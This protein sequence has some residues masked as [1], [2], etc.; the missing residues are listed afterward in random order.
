MADDHLNVAVATDGTLYAA[1]KTSYDSGIY[2]VIALLV[3]RPNGAWDPLREVDRRGTRPIVLI[4]EATTMLRVIY[5]ASEVHDDILEKTTTLAALDFSNDAHVAL[6]G[7]YNNVTSAK[8]NITG[9][10]LILAGGVSATGTAALTWTHPGAPQTHDS[11]VFTSVGTSVAGE[12][13]I[14][15]DL[16]LD[17][18]EIVSVPDAGSVTV[19]G[20][21]G[22]DYEPKADFVGADPFTF[23]A[24]SGSNWSAVATV[25][26]V[27]ASAD[28]LVG[29]WSLDEG[30]GATVHPRRLE[31][32]VA[33]D[34]DLVE[35]PVEVADGPGPVRHLHRQRHRRHG[36]RQG[37]EGTDAGPRHVEHDGA[38]RCSRQT[39]L[40]YSGRARIW[41]ITS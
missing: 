34:L 18:V 5:T 13:D 8:R 11:S 17:E 21:G 4:D 22:F 12:F 39:R 19:R 29:A 2:P 26:V 6:A 14:D 33:G 7:A 23:R 1:V 30:V 27:V 37:H 32:Q 31:H 16:P 28:A 35:H 3:R 20:T 15:S 25:T 40:R 36:H 10:S 24:R 38:H 41:S 9:Q